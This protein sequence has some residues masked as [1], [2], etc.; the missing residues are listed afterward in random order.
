MFVNIRIPYPQNPLIQA[1]EADSS[2]FYFHFFQSVKRKRTTPVVKSM[3]ILNNLKVHLTETKVSSFPI[4]FMCC[5]TSF[6]VVSS[7]LE[8]NWGSHLPKTPCFWSNSNKTK[9]AFSI[10][11]IFIS[12]RFLNLGALLYIVDYC[13]SFNSSIR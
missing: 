6:L 5:I 11:F 9:Y 12:I 1:K 2:L 3:L 10:F 13:I 7:F 8:I 4:I